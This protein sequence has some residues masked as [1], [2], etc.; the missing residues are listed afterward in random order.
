MRIACALLASMALALL[1]T[2]AHAQ[3]GAT[4]LPVG[5]GTLRVSVVR[6]DGGELAGLPVV[7]YALPPDGE[8]GIG[9]GDTDAAGRYAFEG[10]SSDPSTV[11][12]VGVRA[13][14]LPF[15]SRVRFAPGQSELAVTLDVAA[16]STAI[17][18]ARMLSLA[19]RF[20]VACD[21]LR[22]SEAHTLRNDT[23]QV[24]LVPEAA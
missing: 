10:V 4:A 15:G 22:I 3:D 23:E 2:A 13:D 11:Y 19:L 14:D 6:H 8:P 21:G 12:L 9:R 17:E 20:D 18:D 24:I 1:P 5:D 16:P 7:L